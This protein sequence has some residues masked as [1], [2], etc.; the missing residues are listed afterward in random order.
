MLLCVDMAAF[1]LNR[2]VDIW[3]VTCSK[4]APIAGICNLIEEISE[5]VTSKKLRVLEQCSLVI[6]HE[7]REFWVYQLVQFLELPI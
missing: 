7:V 4:C 2:N 6:E 1:I 5:S 3:A